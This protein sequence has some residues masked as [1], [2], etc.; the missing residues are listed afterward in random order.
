MT[1]MAM[2]EAKIPQCLT[3]PYKNKL[4]RLTELDLYLPPPQNTSPSLRPALVYFHGGGLTAGDKTSWFP[5]WL[6]GMLSSL[7]SSPFLHP[8]TEDRA[9]TAGY[10]F[11]APDYQLLPPATGHHILEDIKDLFT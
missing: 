3:F 1:L 11:I 7:I 8:T 9:M 4:G 10:A 5:F 2:A 6:H